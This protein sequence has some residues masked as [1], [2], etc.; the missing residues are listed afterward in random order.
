[1]NKKIGKIYK[2]LSIIIGILGVI[3]SFI[4]SFATA[5]SWTVFVNPESLNHFRVG[6]FFY[7]IALALIKTIFAFLIIYGIGHLIELNQSKE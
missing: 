4:Y 1:M 5:S 3:V 6:I 7:E 2:R